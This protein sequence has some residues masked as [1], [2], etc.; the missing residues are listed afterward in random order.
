ML[1][2]LILNLNRM[3]LYMIINQ[4]KLNQE[5][6]DNTFL[7]FLRNCNNKYLGATKLNKLL[8]YFDFISFRDRN[9]TVTGDI[10]IHKD[11]GPVPD[12]IDDVIVR[13]ASNKSIKVE[14]L[15]YKDGGTF[16]YEASKGPD[17]KVFDSFESDL[18]NKICKEFELWSTDKIVSQTHLEAPWFYS[19]PYEIV[20]YKYSKDIEFFK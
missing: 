16:K 4:S 19:K 14:L 6:Y 15:P 20:N 1:L 7:F 11:Y 17:M 8:Y 10:Y 5:K 9:K 12:N 2:T 13:L 3:K 18:L